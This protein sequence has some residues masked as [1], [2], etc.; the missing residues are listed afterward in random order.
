MLSLLTKTD[1]LSLEA[2]IRNYFRAVFPLSHP[3]GMFQDNKHLH[4]LRLPLL[5]WMMVY[6][7]IVYRFG[8]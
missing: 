2:L 7:P 5:G 8:V 6:S 1:I 4:S 3:G